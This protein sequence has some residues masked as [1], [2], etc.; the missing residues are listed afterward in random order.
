MRLWRLVRRAHLADAFTGEG[1]RR[2]GGRWNSPGVPVTYTSSSLALAV[3]ETLVNLEPNRQPSDLVAVSVDLAEGIRHEG[4]GRAS[5]PTDWARTAAGFFRELGDA[6]VSGGR[7]VALVVPSAVV[8]LETNALLN[9][10]HPDMR[11][12]I[13]GTAVPF[14]FAS[15]PACS[16]GVDRQSRAPCQ[17]VVRFAIRYSPRSRGR[18]TSP[19]RRN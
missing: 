15:I 1:A 8:E 12:L 5:L 7:T 9:P 13:I 16:D 3:L 10:A 18:R 11:R 17:R 4:I 14:R 2:F 19:S 6:W